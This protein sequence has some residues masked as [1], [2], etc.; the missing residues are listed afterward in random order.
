MNEIIEHKQTVKCLG[1]Y[2]DEK[3]DWHEHIN[4]IKSK[5]R[6]GIYAMNKT[7]NYLSTK[8][9]TMLYYSL[10]YPYLDYGISLWGS[11]HTNYI[12]RIT[13]LQ[14]KAIRI[15]LNAQYNDHTIHNH[16]LGKYMYQL[17]K[18]IHVL[19]D[20]LKKII[21]LKSTVHTHNTRNINNPH[22]AHMNNRR[23]NVASKSLRH[24]G[25]VFWYKI[26][27]K[28]KLSYTLNTFK[29]QLKNIY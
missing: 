18:N 5:L 20:H 27:N 13:I 7:K 12:N 14:K 24:K 3:L 26:P 4:Y 16:K 25:P 22:K 6:S 10:I 15:I 8:H 28:I 19:P 1:M 17:V 29:H 2:I 11:T 9:K 21:I 23:T